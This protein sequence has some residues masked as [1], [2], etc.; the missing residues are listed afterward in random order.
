MEKYNGRNF[1]VKTS[2]CDDVC[3]TDRAIQ[4]MKVM[5]DKS[6]PV[7]HD[8]D[9]ILYLY[10]AICPMQ[11]NRL[12]FT[13]K[14]DADGFKE[15]VF[16][17]V[18]LDECLHV[19]F[20]PIDIYVQV[21]LDENSTQLRMSKRY[22][23]EKILEDHCSEKPNEKMIQC[24]RDFAYTYSVWNGQTRKLWFYIDRERF[25]PEYSRIW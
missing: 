10:D 13:I 6:W 12:K 18:S 7:M 17:N 11:F 16:S 8:L 20:E 4:I 15:F 22:E 1:Y 19:I 21:G 5:D 23:L 2:A 14:S 24:S 9:G 3:L 25:E